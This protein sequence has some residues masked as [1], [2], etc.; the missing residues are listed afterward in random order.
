MPLWLAALADPR[1]QVGSDICDPASSAVER[2]LKWEEDPHRRETAVV[3]ALPRT[4]NQDVLEVIAPAGEAR[5]LFTWLRQL[6]FVSRR[7]DSWVYH[8]VVRA[9]MLRLRRAEAPAQWHA[10]HESLAEANAR[11]A[12]DADEVYHLLC[13]DPY[14]NLPKALTSAVKAAEHS[15][16]R[17]RQWAALMSDAARDTQDPDLQEW[18]RCLTD[19]LQ[20][21]DLI[22]YLTC[23]IDNAPLDTPTLVV[24]LEER[25]DSHGIAGRMAEALSDFNHAMELDPHRAW[26]AAHRGETFRLTERFD[27]ALADFSRAIEVDPKY[28]DAIGRRGLTYRAMGRYTDA[29]ADFDRAIRLDRRQAWLI[30]GRGETYQLMRKSFRALDDLNRAIA[31][32]PSYAWAIGSRGQVNRDVEQFHDALA[33]FGR[34]IELDPD[35]AWLVAGRGWT[36][37]LMM[38]FDEALADLGNAIELN[39][40]YIWAICKRGK[41]YWELRRYEDAAADFSRAIGLDHNH[42]LA[43]QWRGQIY[44]SMGRL[45]E[46]H[47]DSLRAQGIKSD[48]IWTDTRLDERGRLL[49]SSPWTGGGGGSNL[50][51]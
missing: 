51:A 8:D 33:D 35:E 24:A 19:S 13:A 3:A 32:E 9:A 16:I 21:N 45:D 39:P 15:L 31:L 43:H 36:Y 37:R 48:H 7:G 5:D 49:L 27:D 30:A 29:L 42:W 17:A 14:A 1:P 50:W 34:A 46:A 22:P 6:P 20:A 47:A 41:I 11:W 25:G 28:I 18:A 44:K 38:R 12:N 23:L 40:E 10:Q 2:F 26:L 4:L